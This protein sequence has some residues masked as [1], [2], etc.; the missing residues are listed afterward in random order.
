MSRE[1]GGEFLAIA[2]CGAGDALLEV[3]ACFDGVAGGIEHVCGDD[4]HVAAGTFEGFV[5]FAVG[6]VGEGVPDNFVYRRAVAGFVEH[7]APGEFRFEPDEVDARA[8]RFEADGAA[9]FDA[10]AGG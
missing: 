5:G 10:E 9:E 2:G 6:G 7:E 4:D 3:A 1:G 8:E